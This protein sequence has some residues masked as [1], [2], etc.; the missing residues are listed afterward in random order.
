MPR[1]FAPKTALYGVE[2][3]PAYGQSSYGDAPEAPTGD[4]IILP[5]ESLSKYR[6][7]GEESPIA[8]PASAPGTIA[9]TIILPTASSFTV[10]S[11]WDGGSILPGET[12]SRHRKPEARQEA[13]PESRRPEHRIEDRAELRTAPQPLAP[14]EPA[15]YEPTEASASYRIDPIAQSEFRQSA[16]VL[17]LETEVQPAESA[18]AESEPE[19]AAAA[20]AHT[21]EPEVPVASHATPAEEADV[22]DWQKAAETVPAHDVT[23]LQETGEMLSAAPAIEPAAHPASHEIADPASPIFHET[24]ILS[25]ADS[26]IGA[27][28]EPAFAPGAGALEEEELIEDDEVQHTSR[29]LH[30]RDGRPRRRGDPRRRSRSRNH[31]PRDVHRPDHSSSRR[32]R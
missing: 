17:E 14:V 19:Q 24:A 10:S 20:H 22:W 27:T 31:D 16:P 30:R 15:E 9:Q 29:Q 4:P 3:A 5:G 7:G 23:A 1:G 6:K 12:L 18:P 13:R 25:P 28:P 32:G 11:D 2:E 26:A 21:V 8:K